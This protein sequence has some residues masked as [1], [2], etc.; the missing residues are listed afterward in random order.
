M[1]KSRILVLL[2]DLRIDGGV[3]NYFRT[4]ELDRQPNITYF[5]VN[6]AGT[7]SNVSRVLSAILIGLVFIRRVT[8]SDMVHVN[9]TLDF[10]SF[11]RDMWFIFVAKLFRKR[12]LVFF[13][14]W[15]Q[16]FE[17]IIKRSRVRSALFR[18][19]Y[20]RVNAYCVLGQNF[21]R[22]LRDLCH[23]N[24]KP[25]HI[26]T[27]VADSRGLD[28]FNLAEKLAAA[29]QHMK[30]LF[31][32]RITKSK[33]IFLAIDA[34]LRCQ[35][36]LQHNSISLYVAGTGPQLHCAIQ[37]VKRARGTGIQFLGEVRGIEKVKLLRACHILLFP[38]TANE[39]L[40]NC[41]LEAM[42]FGMPILSRTSAAIPEHV[43]N[44]VNGFLTDSTE[45][46][47]FARYLRTLV[48]DKVLFRRIASTNHEKAREL[49]T[50]EY[51]RKRLLQ[52]YD[53]ELNR[54]ACGGR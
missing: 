34:F 39:G 29:D 2:P 9:P 43:I 46:E 6:R 19:T 24:D 20:G 48:A 21:A 42:L 30:C 14:G 28:T 7:S 37:Y 11:Y 38:T 32:A 50:T 45:P 49:Y 8:R 36:L 23:V 3:T 51:V 53:M 18:Y 22:K 26:M 35:R 4:L 40:P 10:R 27:T 54:E 41:V 17:Q 1:K 13:R 52:V 44:N 47:V 25:I 33:G 12:V 5:F 31:L 16:E 15:D